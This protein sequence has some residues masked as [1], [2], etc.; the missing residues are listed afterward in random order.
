MNTVKKARLLGGLV[1]GGVFALCI[2]G[3]VAWES[4]GVVWRVLLSLPI[5]YACFLLGCLF[6][7]HWLRRQKHDPSEDWS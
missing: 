4:V 3:L 2:F 6:G 1:G 7:E 5:G